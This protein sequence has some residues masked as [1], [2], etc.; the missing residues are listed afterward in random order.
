MFSLNSQY[1][2]LKKFGMEKLG[3]NIKILWELNVD[4]P[5]HVQIMGYWL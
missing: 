4:F 5:H 3:E 2:A 1:F